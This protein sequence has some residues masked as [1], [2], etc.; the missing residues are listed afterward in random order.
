VSHISVLITIQD[1]K[2]DCHI[3]SSFYIL[4]P[5]RTQLFLL[6]EFMKG[7]YSPAYSHG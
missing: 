1:P 4:Y 2:R 5:R 7:I 3:N 6:S